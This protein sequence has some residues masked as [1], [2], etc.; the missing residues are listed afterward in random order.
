[1]YFLVF[2]YFLHEEIVT[3]CSNGT[4]NNKRTG[5]KKERLYLHF[6]FEVTFG[7]EISFLPSPLPFFD[8]K[9]CEQK[10]TK[11]S[12]L[13]FRYIRVAEDE[14]LP[15]RD[16]LSTVVQ[17]L[18]V[19]TDRLEIVTLQECIPVGYVPPPCRRYPIVS[20][21]PSI[22]GKSLGGE[23]P[24]LGHTHPQDGTWLS[25]IP[26]WKG[27]RTRDPMSRFAPALA[28]GCASHSATATR[29]NSSILV[30]ETSLE[31][32]PFCLGCRP[33]GCFTAVH[34]SSMF[35]NHFVMLSKVLALVMSYTS[36]MPMAPL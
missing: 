8:I 2:T 26:P 34:T 27:H 9:I 17:L 20:Q 35:R 6:P 16:R 3:D 15:S 11:N 10:L 33:K 24:P 1:M 22:W 13:M 29:L 7:Y 4:I 5:R 18:S 21:V 19:H 31:P 23:Y 12:S 30:F 32:H 36:M 14:T 28:G 25:Q